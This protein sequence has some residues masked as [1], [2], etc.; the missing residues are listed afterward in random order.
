MESI[1]NSVNNTRKWKASE[2]MVSFVLLGCLGIF[3]EVL[4][5][6]AKGP[7]YYKMLPDQNFE[8][9]T[10]RKLWKNGCHVIEA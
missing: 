3:L 4:R 5:K 2:A 7:K 8:P 1:M 9:A 6:T 10:F